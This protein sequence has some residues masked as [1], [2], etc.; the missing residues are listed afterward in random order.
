M[1]WRLITSTGFISFRVWTDMAFVTVQIVR[2]YN[3]DWKS[4]ATDT[5]S[6]AHSKLYSVSGGAFPPL[7][8]WWP[9]QCSSLWKSL[10]IP[11]HGEKV[12]IAWSARFWWKWPVNSCSKPPSSST[13]NW[14]LPFQLQSGSMLAPYFAGHGCPVLGVHYL[15]TMVKATPV[16][17]RS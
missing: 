3:L 1:Q 6:H 16:A 17:C 7:C 11:Y 13:A 12:P 5:D 14:L 9:L 10:R 2:L 15:D 4:C 8:G